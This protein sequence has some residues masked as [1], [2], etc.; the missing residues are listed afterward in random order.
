MRAQLLF[1][2]SALLPRIRC[3]C[4]KSRSAAT[5]RALRLKAAAAA[6]PTTEIVDAAELLRLRDKQ[7]GCCP[8]TED[9]EAR[10]AVR[11]LVAASRE[12]R[13]GIAA[14]QQSAAVKALK[15]WVQALELTKGLLHGADVDG[16]P[17]EIMGNVFIKYASACGSA[18]LRKDTDERT[19]PGV[20]FYPLVG[21]EDDA[22]K[23][24]LLPLELFSR[25]SLPG[26]DSRALR[27]HAV[28]AGPDVAR[29]EFG[30]DGASP[31]ALAELDAVLE[32]FELVKLKTGAGKKKLAR[33]LA[34][35]DVVP[36]LDRPGRP[37]YVAQVVG[38][39]ALLYRRRDGEVVVDLEALRRD[40]GMD[41]LA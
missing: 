23:Q 7:C 19:P 18:N 9:D 32:S 37:C 6:I 20:L 41:L 13:L 35:N 26:K 5:K 10:D 21:E 25:P 8:P 29:F 24:Y 3:H 30:R 16:K 12:V 40:P 1:L 34:E 27:A 39:T 14:P 11:T 4:P 36:F 38:H 2:S 28:R 15:E 33:A 17:L 22:S 31:G